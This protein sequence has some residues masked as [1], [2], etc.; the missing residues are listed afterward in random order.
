MSADYIPQLQAEKGYYD[1]LW[2]IANPSKGAE[3]GGAAAVTFFQ[4]SGVD[5]G[6]L[7]QIWSLSTPLA[8]MTLPQFYTAVRLITMFQNGEIPLNKGFYISN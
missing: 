6:I 1:L 3:L 2:T 5:I 7:K 4:R 8:T